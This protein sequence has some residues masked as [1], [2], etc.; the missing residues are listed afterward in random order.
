MQSSLNTALPYALG[1]FEPSLFEKALI[2]DGTF[3]GEAELQQRWTGEV[4]KVIAQTRLTLPAW[5]DVKPVYG[6]RVG[7]HSE[8]LQPLL[9]EMSA[10]FRIDPAAEW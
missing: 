7:R 8:H 6:G 10:V 4:E 5:G 3:A 1:L 9:D 2:S